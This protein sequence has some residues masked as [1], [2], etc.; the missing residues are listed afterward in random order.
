MT[1]SLSL[2]IGLVF[3][4]LAGLSAFAISFRGYR[5]QQLESAIVWRESLRAAVF[6]FSFF[7]VSSIV[8]GYVLRWVI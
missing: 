5:R 7:L 8:L 4:I 2:M 6:A 1:L 3:G